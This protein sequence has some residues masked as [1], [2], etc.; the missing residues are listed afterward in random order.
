MAKAKGKAG[1][2][3][4]WHKQPTRHSRAKKYGKAGGIYASDSTI[5]D[6][7]KSS[8]K[9]DESRLKS[10]QLKFGYNI[11]LTPSEKRFVFKTPNR[12]GQESR[13][14][15]IAH[16]RKNNPKK[17]AP[18][19]TSQDE[20]VRKIKNDFSGDKTAVNDLY[21]FTVNDYVVWK[22]KRQP[23]ENNLITRIKKGTYNTDG[24]LIAFRNVAD[25]GNRE[26]LKENNTP[27]SVSVRNS[28]AKEM[29]E[30]FED[31]YL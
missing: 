23:V 14:I 2:G 10:T 3:Q 16:K 19:T 6:L 31:E 29:L 1:Y 11:K 5:S 20:K 8:A 13:F 18:L 21:L 17:Q 24:G 15:Q 27:F 4:G 9:I 12:Q 22:S 25:E 28:V 30:D 7:R 26:Y